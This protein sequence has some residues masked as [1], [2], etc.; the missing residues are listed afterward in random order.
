MG[1]HQTNLEQAKRRKKEEAGSTKRQSK[2]KKERKKER[3]KKASK[4]ARVSFC[5]DYNNKLSIE[6]WD[7]KRKTLKKLDP[8]NFESKQ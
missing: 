6:S 1:Q 8:I 7:L 2:K 4:Q 5:T 3:K